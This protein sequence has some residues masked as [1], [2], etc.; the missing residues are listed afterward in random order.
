MMANAL[1]AVGG[2][3]TKTARPYND[4][5][6]REAAAALIANAERHLGRNLDR[7]LSDFLTAQVVLRDFNE[8][9]SPLGG[10]AVHRVARGCL[11]KD[12]H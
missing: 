10:V 5:I 1:P 7:L 2:A 9:I 8:E 3:D 12:V 4:A 6:L 11:A